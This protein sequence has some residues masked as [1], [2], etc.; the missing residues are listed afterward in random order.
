MEAGGGQEA[1]DLYGKEHP[2]LIWMDIRMPGMDGYEA[3][4]RIREVERGRS[5]GEGKDRHVPIIALTAG[6]MENAG[7]ISPLGVFDDW[8]YKP[9]R[10]EEVFERLERHLGVQ[11]DYRDA[12]SEA[13]EEKPREKAPLSAAD[14]TSLPVKWL[15]EFFQTAR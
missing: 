2:D 3:A 4:G 12:A 1:V 15:K 10:E 14:L 7:R 13:V 9:F 11:F 6:M 5:K 8:V